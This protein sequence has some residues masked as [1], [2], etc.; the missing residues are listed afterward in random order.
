M[1]HDIKPHDWHFESTFESVLTK[2]IYITLINHHWA[3][4]WVY[5]PWEITVCKKFRQV[6]YE[7]IC[8]IH[9]RGWIQTSS[10]FNP[11]SDGFDASPEKWSDLTDMRCWEWGM[12]IRHGNLSLYLVKCFL[13]EDKCRTTCK[14]LTERLAAR[15]SLQHSLWSFRCVRCRH[16]SSKSISSLEVHCSIFSSLQIPIPIPQL[17]VLI[18]YKCSHFSSF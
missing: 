3:T 16:W 14:D 8:I 5:N 6:K 11:G 12:S 2:L 10:N 4:V 18:R 1:V 7:Y 13:V 17:K 15:Q 9:W